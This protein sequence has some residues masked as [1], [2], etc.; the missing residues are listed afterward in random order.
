MTSTNDLVRLTVVGGRRRLDLSVPSA[1]AVAEL[2]PALAR[3][4]GL[5]DPALAHSELRPTTAGGL[6]LATDRSLGDQGVRDGDV[7]TL[8]VDADPGAVPRYDDIVEAVADVVESATPAWTPADGARTAVGAATALLVTG[9]GLVVLSDLGAAAAAAIVGSAALLALLAAVVLDRA[10]APRGAG[11]VIGVVGCFLA[12]LAGYLGLGGLTDL[13]PG[14]GSPAALGVGAGVAALA[15][16]IL[17][18]SVR[19]LRQA[20]AVP[21]VVALAAAV[22]AGAG[23]FGAAPTRIATVTA[24]ALLG[25]APLVLPWLALAATPIRVLSP[26]EDAEILA[27][28]P[29]IDPALVRL[30]LLQGHWLLVSL[31]I[32]AGIALLGLTPSVVGTGWPGVALA[33]VVYLAVLLDVRDSASRADVATGVVVGVV[34]VLTTAVVVALVA[35]AWTAALM[36]T[37]LVAGVAVLVLALLRTERHV[38]L[39]RVADV[40]R[41]VLLAA[42]PLLGVVAAGGGGVL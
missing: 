28:P 40:A 6:V 2:L 32:G 9:A 17:A 33:L 12:G 42:V 11:A 8:V 30:E 34:G 13:A 20:A 35:P 37:L 15:A 25:C 1:V 16:G 23:T 41:G 14:S 29:V 38:R 4:L 7:L 3:R 39:E 27:E 24:F 5:L 19:T 10:D 18:A 22:V 21:A 26:R 36:V 31:R